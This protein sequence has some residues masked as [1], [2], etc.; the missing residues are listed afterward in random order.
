MKP[1]FVLIHNPLMGPFTWSATGEA[2]KKLGHLIIAPSLAPAL[3][4]KPPYYAGC[5]HAVAESVRAA[6]PNDG[7]VLVAHGGA[8]ALIPAVVAAIQSPV[9]AAIFV[10]AMMP[11]PGRSWF[12]VAPVEFTAQ[13]T[14]L[15][16]EGRL[17]T[18]DAWFKPDVF[19]AMLPDSRL[20]RQVVDALPPMPLAFFAELA[21]PNDPIKGLPIGCLQLT[22]GYQATFEDAQWMKWPTRQ[23]ISNQF[24]MLTQPERIAAAIDAL[25]E[26]VLKSR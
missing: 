5:A 15:A 2:L 23:E 26:E 9:R 21:P 14:H 25:A 6:K 7:V 10:D 8:G 17:P 16:K 4:G 18:W 12:D 19:N 13:L 22:K 11:H 20:R 24:A 1:A 3:A